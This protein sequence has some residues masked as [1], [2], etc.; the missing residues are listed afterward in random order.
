MPRV[1]FTKNLERHVH[2]P[3]TRVAGTTV[4]QVLCAVFAENPSVRAYVVDE[5]GALR[6]HMSVFVDGQQIKDRTQLSDAVL[7]DSEI[8]IM[9]ALSGG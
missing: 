2:C 4:A 6:K 7:P 8:Y 5:Q 3:T 9:Q 1:A